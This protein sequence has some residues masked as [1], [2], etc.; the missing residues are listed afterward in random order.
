MPKVM[1]Q[2][3]A[4]ASCDNCNKNSQT[5]TFRSREYCPYD[6]YKLKLLLTT[7]QCFLKTVSRKIW[8]GFEALD[9]KLS[10]D[11]QLN[12][13]TKFLLVVENI[14]NSQIIFQHLRDRYFRRISDISRNEY[15]LCVVI[16]RQKGHR[17]YG[18]IKDFKKSL[19][20]SFNNVKVFTMVFE[21]LPQ[22]TDPLSVI[23][24]AVSELDV[25]M[26][27]SQEMS[28][29]N[30]TVESESSNYITTLKC[31][32][33]FLSSHQ[34]DVILWSQDGTELARLIISDV[35]S[36]RGST[37]VRERASLVPW[38]LRTVSMTPLAS[39]MAEELHLFWQ[40]QNGDQVR[41]D[42]YPNQDHYPCEEKISCDNKW[43]N[44]MNSVHPSIMAAVVRTIDKYG[45]KMP[46]DAATKVLKECAICGMLYD[47]Q[48][49]VKEP[50]CRNETLGIVSN[51]QK[52]NINYLTFD[53][54]E[55]YKKETE[56]SCYGCQISLQK[57]T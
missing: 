9:R 23:R 31:I 34:A 40:L 15:E 29:I 56:H 46:L 6:L 25:K 13:C 7:S 47:T 44:M 37:I 38:N 50:L 32:N 36:G 30:I 2:G 8:K 41:N 11:C 17:E 12:C 54:L 14:K 26:G 4:G 45:F 35:M 57:L 19:E 10:T 53:I 24:E 52:Y 42:E 51:S 39:L 22:A 16:L 28:E 55:S 1:E 18:K 43:D 3:A 49:V 27:L 33:L 5:Y 20:M 21:I 48:S